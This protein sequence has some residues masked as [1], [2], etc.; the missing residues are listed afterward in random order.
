MLVHLF[1]ITGFILFIFLSNSLL[2]RKSSKNLNC[3]LILHLFFYLMLILIK[4]YLDL[5]SLLFALLTIRF[6]WHHFTLKRKNSLCGFLERRSF[7]SSLIRSHFSLRQIFL[8]F[9]SLKF[10]SPLKFSLRFI[11]EHHAWRFLIKTWTIFCLTWLNDSTKFGVWRLWLYLFLFTVTLIILFLLFSNRKDWL[12]PLKHFLIQL[13]ISE[14]W[15]FYSFTLMN[16]FHFLTF[17]KL[18]RKQV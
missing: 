14:A 2:V 13:H 4:V 8:I 17:F 3:N 12:F 1:V 7:T 5:N 11:H 10:I 16:V 9:F 6:F 18:V 15:A